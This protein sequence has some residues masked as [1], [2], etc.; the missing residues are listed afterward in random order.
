M[1]VFP[2]CQ[3]DKVRLDLFMGVTIVDHNN[4]NCNKNENAETNVNGKSSGMN[5]RALGKE[6][7][8]MNVV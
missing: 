8:T 6:F 2:H 7:T 1:T 5:V 3:N 4:G